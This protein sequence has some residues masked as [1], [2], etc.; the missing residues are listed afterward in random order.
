MSDE[1][2]S[3]S[4]LDETANWVGFIQCSED[5]LDAEDSPD[6]KDRAVSAGDSAGEAL[7]HI[8]REARTLNARDSAKEA[9]QHDAE[10][11][12]EHDTKKVLEYGA[13]E[14]LDI[15]IDGPY[16]KFIS[17]VMLYKCARE[18]ESSN[19]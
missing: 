12:L 15:D 14:A 4:G 9:L 7:W 1:S 5:S 2:E 6:A 10:K 16:T 11:A 3:E 13:R 18:A 17:E 8:V 19:N